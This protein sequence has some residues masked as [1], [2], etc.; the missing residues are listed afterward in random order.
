MQVTSFDPLKADKR[1]RLRIGNHFKIC[2]I[3]WSLCGAGQLNRRSTSTAKALYVWPPKSTCAPR[4]AGQLRGGNSWSPLVKQTN[5]D[6]PL[7]FGMIHDSELFFDNL[8]FVDILLCFG[9]FFDL[10]VTGS[11]LGLDE[12]TMHLTNYSVNKH[13]ACPL[14]STG[15]KLPSWNSMSVTCGVLKISSLLQPL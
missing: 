14:L 9:W 11:P 10:T 8:C 3:S 15:Q 4:T 12:R 6:I 5:K 2:K 1:K 7:N 13:A